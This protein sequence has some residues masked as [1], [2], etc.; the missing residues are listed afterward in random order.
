MLY[1]SGDGCFSTKPTPEDLGYDL[2]GVLLST[3]RDYELLNSILNRYIRL[4]KMWRNTLA[5]V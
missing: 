5:L 3:K 1:I 4:Y 2:G